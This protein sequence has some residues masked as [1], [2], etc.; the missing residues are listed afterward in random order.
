MSYPDNQISRDASRHLEE[1]SDEFRSALVRG[2]FPTWA[3]SL[4]LTR[5][6]D[7]LKTTFPIPLDAA[8]YKELKGDIKFR[9]LYSRSLSMKTKEWFDGVEE[10]AIVLEAPDFV[11]WAG[12]PAIMGQ[13]WLRQPNVMAAAMLAEGSYA[14]P[15][16]DLYAD[17]DTKA[18]ST[19]RLFA[20]GHPFNVLDTNLGTFDNILTTTEAQ[21]NSG[22]FFDTANAY[23]RS[24][25]GA[26]G[27]NLGLRFTNGGH[28]LV[29]AARENLFKNF[30]QFDTI[31]RTIQNA[32]ADDN[33]AAV[34]QNNI[35][36]SGIGY[37][38]G[39]ELTHDDYFYVLAA[40]RPG[41]HPW[42]VQKESSPKEIVHDYDSELYKRQLKLGVAYVGRA[43]IAAAMP[44]CIAR[45]QIT[46]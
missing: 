22:A 19:K 39:D 9:S 5:T 37:T 46:G 20:T 16:L 24:I 7:A 4:G 13:E 14:G 42:V 21:I 8:G 6:S 27:Q 29:P 11:D 2:D 23:F 12:Q 45:V 28:C 34:T 31:V 10:K 35:Y 17:P 43:N 40:G 44:H 18:A 26:N 3:D 25:K 1:F 32:A 36:K 33:V 15:L 30:L 41:M 38:V